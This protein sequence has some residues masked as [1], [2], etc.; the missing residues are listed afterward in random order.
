MRLD[1]HTARGTAAGPDGHPITKIRLPH[2]G[3]HEGVGRIIFIGSTVRPV[4]N[5]IHVGALVGIRFAAAACHRC[6]FC[7]SGMEQYCPRAINH[8]HHR[9][10]SFQEYIALDADYLT[11]L[12]DDCDPITTGPTLCAGVTS[13]K[14]Q[15]L[16]RSP[17]CTGS[18]L[19]LAVAYS[20]RADA[21]TFKYTDFTGRQ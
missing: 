10:G 9:D 16:R 13:Y 12:S 20:Y 15:L 3:G 8:L 18:G 21:T 5:D 14:V 4:D 7:L 19:P 2:C 1:L 11:L 6:E 17:L